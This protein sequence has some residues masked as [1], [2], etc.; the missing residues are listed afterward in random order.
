ML[1]NFRRTTERGAAAPGGHHCFLFLLLEARAVLSF[2][3]N[4]GI[5]CIVEVAFIKDNFS[6]LSMMLRQKT[7]KK[8]R[9]VSV[10]PPVVAS[11]TGLEN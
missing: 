6:C 4:A 9:N 11:N 10:T 7:C 1:G 8:E 2:F 3:R 5:G